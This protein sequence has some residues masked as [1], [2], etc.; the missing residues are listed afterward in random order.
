MGQAGDT[1]V[2]NEL[3]AL[4]S[5]IEE[6]EFRLN[7]PQVMSAKQLSDFLGISTRTFYEMKSEGNTPPAIY[8]SQRTVRYD[9]DGVMN[10]LKTQ[11]VG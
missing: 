2:S 5:R 11:E 1:V 9:L 10:W 7:T 6:L 3:R 4:E 8:L